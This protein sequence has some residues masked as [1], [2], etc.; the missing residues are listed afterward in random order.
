MDAVN[1]TF[2]AYIPYNLGKPLISYFEG[3]PRFSPDL[4]V[5]YT[6][7]K[8]N[9]MTANMYGCNW[10]PEPV[11][12]TLLKRFFATDDAA[13]HNKNHKT[14]TARLKLEGNID[15]TKVGRFTQFDAK[16]IFFDKHNPKR[17]VYTQH[18]DLSRC[19]TAGIGYEQLV[20]AGNFVAHGNK[21]KGFF[22]A[23]LPERSTELATDIK[24]KNDITGPYFA[25][26]GTPASA[27]CDT[28]IIDVSGSAGYPYLEPLSPNIDLSL[29]IKLIKRGNTV[30]VIIE[31][32]HNKFPAY[33]LLI[34][35]NLIYSYNPVQHGYKGPTPFNLNQSINFQKSYIATIRSQTFM[36]QQTVKRP[37]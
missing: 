37:F 6:E 4:M 32:T 19:I 5:N 22:K 24:L 7:F 26:A 34:D 8:S 17:P 30:L 10:I 20:H 14:H 12:G 21:W 3:D 25:A 13:F 16:S 27:L 11:T 33:E 15:L 29:K 36:N 23:S 9:L 2:Q 35:N 28:T 18:S 1:I 31:G